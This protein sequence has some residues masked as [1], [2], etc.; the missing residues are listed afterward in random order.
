MYYS[1]EAIY[2]KKVENYTELS[3]FATLGLWIIQ[4]VG[5]DKEKIEDLIGEYP[6][7]EA[8]R[9]LTQEDLEII[10]MCKKNNLNYKVTD[11][12]IKVG[13]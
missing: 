11:K 4:M 12:G 8:D 2:Y 9:E 5:G 3:R 13:T 1:K 7:L 10:E 6:S